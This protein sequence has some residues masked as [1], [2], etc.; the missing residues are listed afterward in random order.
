[1]RVIDTE[2][3]A[4]TEYF[5]RVVFLCASAMESVRLLLNSAT[6]ALPAG[7]ANSSGLVGHYLMDHITGGGA[8][9]IL[10]GFDEGRRYSTGYSPGMLYMPRFRNVER[11]HPGFIRGY[12]MQGS[13]SLPGWRRGT[14]T[15]LLG[16]VLKE[17]L[18]DPG[19]WRVG[20]SGCGEC[21]PHFDNRMTIHQDK[22]D[23][24]GIPVPHFDFD[25]DDNARAMRADMGV[26]TA[27]MLAAA[28]VRDIRIHNRER[29][30][31]IDNHEM[32]GARMGRDPRTSVLN[33]Y[34]QAHDIPNLFI[35]DGACMTSAA[36]QNPSLT[37]MALTARACDFAVRQLK[38][39]KI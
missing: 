2:T 31:G 12:H 25:W 33:A 37:Y 7:L 13:A 19:P 35:T 39:A 32:G 4:T 5:A 9:G 18:R 30:P 8:S 34:N 14:E 15:P 24:W 16:A 1:M 29:P 3:R 22:V 36:N 17:T 11:A 27:E 28:G 38:A 21:L 26:A 6:T 20:L 23:A 10:D